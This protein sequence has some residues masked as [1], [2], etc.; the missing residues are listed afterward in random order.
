MEAE[1]GQILITWVHQ[2]DAEIDRVILAHSQ[3]RLGRRKVAAVELELSLLEGVEDLRMGSPDVECPTQSRCRIPNK[4]VVA[5][6]V[7]SHRMEELA[8]PGKE[9]NLERSVRLR[10]TR[11]A[12][13]GLARDAHNIVVGIKGLVHLCHTIVWRE[14]Q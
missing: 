10:K 7:G 2:R 9:S 13:N 14:S 12:V 1:P 6:C 8:T 4:Q 3:L 5:V 11:L